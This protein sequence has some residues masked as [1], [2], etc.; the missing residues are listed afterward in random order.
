MAC[1]ACN[2]LCRLHRI[3]SFSVLR[4]VD[5]TVVSLS[6]FALLIIVYYLRYHIYKLLLKQAAGLA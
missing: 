4:V 5:L 1:K 2:E 6:I 3:T